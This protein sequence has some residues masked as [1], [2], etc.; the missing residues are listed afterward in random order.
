[1]KRKYQK[2]RDSAKGENCTLTLH[3]YCNGNPE[4]TS[5]NHIST[6]YNSGMGIKPQD[7]FG[8][9]GCDTCHAIIDGRM[10]VNDQLLPPEEI[11]AAKMRA[12]FATWNRWID[13]GLIK[14]G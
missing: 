8:V 2:L 5:L 9:F 10:K 6:A 1:M 13:M 12:L 3:P 14:I 4:T 11:E 7:W